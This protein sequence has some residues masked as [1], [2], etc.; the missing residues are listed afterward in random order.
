M[1]RPQ[2]P[3]KIRFGQLESDIRNQDMAALSELPEGIN[4]MLFDSLS[5]RFSLAQ[6]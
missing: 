3:V 2:P 1:Y 6:I 4:Y 5:K